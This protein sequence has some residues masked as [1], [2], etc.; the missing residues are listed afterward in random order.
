MSELHFST[1]GSGTALVILHGLFGSGRNWQSH[2]RQFAEHFQVFSVDLRNHG[3][4]FHANEMN[5]SAMAEDV[6]QLLHRLELSD[7]YMLGHSM[8]GKVA[9]MLAL[10]NP[11]LVKRM[12]VADIAPVDYFHHYDD[13]INPILALP[14]EKIE[15][16]AQADQLLRQN[17][18]EDQLRAFLLQNLVREASGWRWR[19]NW[20]VIQRDMEWLT[21][22]G[23]LPQD[24]CI[25]LPTLFLRGEKSDYIGET[26]VVVIQQR[27][28]NYRIETIEAAGHWLHAEKPELFNRLVADF[29]LDG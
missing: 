24:W 8:G 3:E 25:D 28:R 5:Y 22:F 7:C 10:Q 17:V 11:A 18:P 29:L 13:L 12:I 4:S 15:S 14:L 6:A 19:V 16:R 23:D 21:G 9:M 26:E 2:A 1:S 27:F 20:E